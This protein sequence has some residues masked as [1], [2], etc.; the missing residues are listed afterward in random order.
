[1]YTLKDLNM[2]GQEVDNLTQAWIFGDTKSTESIITKKLEDKRIS[3]IFEKLIYER[4]RNMAL[5]IEDFLR[6]KE[7][8]F[9]IVGAGHLVGNKGVIEMLRGKGYLVEQL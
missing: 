2:L 4:N 3:S 9:V 1:M 5:K 6:K 7:T 8:H